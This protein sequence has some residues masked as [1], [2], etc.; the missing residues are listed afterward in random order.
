MKY[1]SISF[2]IGSVL[3]KYEDV[4]YVREKRSHSPVFCCR[5]RGYRLLVQESFYA[6]FRCFFK[7]FVIDSDCRNLAVC[8]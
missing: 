4:G 6:S 5:G 8:G 2:G 3:Q 1:S 7:F